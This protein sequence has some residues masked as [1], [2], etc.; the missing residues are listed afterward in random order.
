MFSIFIFFYFLTYCLLYTNVKSEYTFFNWKRL[1]SEPISSQDS[2]DTGQD[3]VT[4]CP[5]CT[6]R[7]NQG[8]NWVHKVMRCFLVSE[9]HSCI[10]GFL[11]CSVACCLE[12]VSLGSTDGPWTHSV[13]Y[14]DLKLLAILLSQ[15]LKCWI[16]G[17]YYHAW[18]M[19]KF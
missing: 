4:W 13:A 10:M 3:Y 15:S 11:F 9:G 5:V 6:I 12:T 2:E 19:L 7:M 8:T 17:M 14:A 1:L 18:S 16:I